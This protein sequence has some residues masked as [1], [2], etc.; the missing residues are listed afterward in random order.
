MAKPAAGTAR[1]STIYGPRYGGQVSTDI[2]VSVLVPSSFIA[3][4]RNEA[5]INP[6]KLAVAFSPRR[7]K[8]VVTRCWYVAFSPLAT[9]IPYITHINT[10]T[11]ARFIF[12]VA[13][14]PA[15]RCGLAF[16]LGLG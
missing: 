4:L 9:E 6:V 12:L 3:L 2:R 15:L 11:H 16:A 8:Y 1:P 7:L 14:S 10:V 5:V 13:W